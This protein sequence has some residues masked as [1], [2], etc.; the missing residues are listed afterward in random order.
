MPI[1][2]AMKSVSVMEEEQPD[3]SAQELNAVLNQLLPIRRQRLSRAERQL[4]QAEQTL[5][6]TEAAL[7]AQQ[8]QLEQLQAEWRQQRDTFLREAL[9]K[10][11][12]LESLKNQ[13]EQEQKQI[14]QIQAQVL[15]CTDWQQQY[16][17]RQQLVGQARE[18]A[19]LCQKAV[20]KLE[21]LLTTYLEA[22]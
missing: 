19:R 4:R 21:F 13:L 5:R 1:S 17:H 15:L 12:T 20:E 11:Q 9:G 7:R 2:N 22:I 16:L 8:A 6:Q 3:T 14:R 18:A 10:T